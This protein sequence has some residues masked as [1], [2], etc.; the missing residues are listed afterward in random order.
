MTTPSETARRIAGTFVEDDPAPKAP[1]AAWI[2][3]ECRTGCF[4]ETLLETIQQQDEPLNVELAVVEKID[5]DKITVRIPCRV[6]DHESTSTFGLD[7]FFQINP[8]T[9]KAQRV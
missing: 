6:A 2:Q 8:L 4:R 5:P 7:V 1:L 9:H 3:A